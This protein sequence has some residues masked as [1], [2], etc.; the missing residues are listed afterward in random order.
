MSNEQAPAR[1]GERL[2]HGIRDSDSLACEVASTS[3]FYGFLEM[4]GTIADAIDQDAED[5]MQAALRVVSEER[6]ACAS[7][8]QAAGCSCT[9][10]T[11]PWIGKWAH[12]RNG[13]RLFQHDPRCP[14]HLASG[15]RARGSSSEPTTQDLDGDGRDGCEYPG[16]EFE[17]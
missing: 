7:L 2:R 17:G 6:E 9:Q 8:V 11:S 1:F 15:L 12:N 5:R 3:G 13:W 4:L 16:A 10:E 14:H